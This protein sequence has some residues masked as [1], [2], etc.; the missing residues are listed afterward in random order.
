MRP[1]FGSDVYD[2]LF[3][4][5][6]TAESIVNQ[7]VASCFASWFPY[8]SLR[9]VKAS[10]VDEVLEFDVYYSKGKGNDIEAVNVKTSLLTRAG[11]TIKEI[12]N[13]R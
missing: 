4:N 6:S 1:N 5:Q 7:A 8:L 2:S 13:G 11:D 9:S 3:E 10:L 12:S